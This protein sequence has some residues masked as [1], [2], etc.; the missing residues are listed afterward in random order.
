MAHFQ[1]YYPTRELE[2]GEAR[3][4]LDTY[5]DDT[6]RDELVWRLAERDA[7]QEAGG[8]ERYAELA[9]PDRIGLTSRYETS[10]IVE[11]EE[12]GLDRLHIVQARGTR[13]SAH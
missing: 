13:R 5:D 2:E 9:S 3:T 6:F 12:H 7:I 1:K 11:F 10:Y 8:L 4:F